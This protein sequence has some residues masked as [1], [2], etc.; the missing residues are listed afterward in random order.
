MQHVNGTPQICGASL[1]QTM[2]SPQDTGNQQQHL[3]KQVSTIGRPPGIMAG[4]N[5]HC[6]P[7]S[8]INELLEASEPLPKQIASQLTTP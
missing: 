5:R 7:S 8:L 1:N 3:A 6:P 2:Y 4:R